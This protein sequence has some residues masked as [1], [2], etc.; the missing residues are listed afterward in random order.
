MTQNSTAVSPLTPL[1]KA[2]E[3]MARNKY[4]CL[5][6]VDGQNK[7]VGIVTE[8]DIFKLVAKKL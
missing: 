3:I 4:G 2:V 7:V 6:V 8:T 1:S 5:P